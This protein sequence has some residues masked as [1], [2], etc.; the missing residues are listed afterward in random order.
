MLEVNRLKQH[1]DNS[2]HGKNV[3][4]SFKYLFHFIITIFFWRFWLWDGVQSLTDKTCAGTRH[5]ATC[6]KFKCQT[7]KNLCIAYTQVN[8]HTFFSLSASRSA[9]SLFFSMKLFHTEDTHL[10]GSCVPLTQR[11]LKFISLTPDKP[12]PSSHAQE[13]ERLGR[14]DATGASDA[15]QDQGKM[16]IDTNTSYSVRTHAHTK[17]TPESTLTNSL[18]SCG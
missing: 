5:S 12:P 11:R 3:L 15:F 7:R 18:T 10:R 16:D 9:P 6:G 17:R 8:T 13:A 2:I 14:P 1:E 4:E